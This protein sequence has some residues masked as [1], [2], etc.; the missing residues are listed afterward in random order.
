MW[1]DKVAGTWRSPRGI[2]LATLSIALQPIVLMFLFCWYL[3]RHY[4]LFRHALPIL[5]LL[6]IVVLIIFVRAAMKFL[7]LRLHDPITVGCNSHLVWPR[8]FSGKL[9]LYLYFVLIL[10]FGLVLRPWWEGCLYSLIS[11][12]TFVITYSVSRIGYASLWCWSANILPIVC[13]GVRLFTPRKKRK[14]KKRSR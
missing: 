14:A 8:I 2:F 3:P 9:P 11:I 1:H 13:L 4:S 5:L 6:S 12:I 10:G 7:S